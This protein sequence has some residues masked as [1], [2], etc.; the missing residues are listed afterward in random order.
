MTLLEIEVVISTCW[1]ARIVWLVIQQTFN[2]SIPTFNSRYSE[3]KFQKISTFKWSYQ[4]QLRFHPKKFIALHSGVDRLQSSLSF[5]FFWKNNSLISCIN[6]WVRTPMW[7]D[8][9]IKVFSNT[10]WLETE[11]ANSTLA[12]SN[13]IHFKIYQN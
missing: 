3:L 9:S 11:I 8:L 5:V 12:Y 1:I 10:P 2:Q 7:A 4:S 13:L 6:I